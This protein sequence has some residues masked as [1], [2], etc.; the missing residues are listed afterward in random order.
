MK[1]IKKI[2]ICIIV[3]IIIVI[4]ALIFILIRKQDNNTIENNNTVI[5]NNESTA[6]SEINTEQTEENI[7]SENFLQVKQ[8]IQS[9]LDIL[10]KNNSAYYRKDETGEFVKTVSDEEI[11]QSIYNKLS[12][13][14]I[15]QNDITVE[16]VYDFVD[17]NEESLI[18]IIVDMEKNINNGISQY[19][20]HTANL[21]N[22]TLVG[23]KYYIINVNDS[24][25][26]YSVEPIENTE[27]I[28]TEPVQ[29]TKND[30]NSIPNV[31]V[32]DETICNEYLLNL[33]R[34]MVYLP[35]IAFD[36][37]DEEYRNKRFQNIDN[38]K[39]YVEENKD[40]INTLTLDK[41]L[42]N[43]YEDY[44]E[45][46][47]MYQHQNTYVFNVKE[48]VDYTVKLDTYTLIT[49]KF[50]STYESADNQTKVMMNMN[51]W[52][53]MINNKD[54]EN[55]Y[56][57]L[58]ETYRNNT[59]ENLEDFKQR[60]KA[61]FTS[62]YTVEYS[63]FSEE[64]GTYILGYSLKDK[65]SDFD[66]GISGNVLMKF[67]EGTDFVMSFEMTVTDFN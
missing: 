21:S 59:Y 42:K 37:L 67:K 15:E 63:D 46:V 13:N 31:R 40:Y 44:T 58:D 7:S 51:K 1:N 56:N 33:K 52:V 12:E 27:N 50:K 6:D 29:I 64:N 53:E 32:N 9:Y 62:Y 16:N 8:I 14:Y 4:A 36:K 2:I 47:C 43:E 48:A 60:A 18:A 55:A 17:D 26:A 35:E 20:V 66:P 19:I 45:Y 49:D 34:L 65:L 28:S 25:K 23:E 11:K 38:F 24:E 30:G 10:N 61:T 57:L 41:Y 54:Y 3:L 39:K 22:D 5:N